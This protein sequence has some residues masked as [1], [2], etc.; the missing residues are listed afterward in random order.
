M[1]I[2][3]LDIT[4]AKA[5]DV[6]KPQPPRADIV[7]KIVKRQL[8][9]QKEDVKRWRDATTIAERQEIAPD[10]KELIKIYKDV[11]LDAH[12]SSLMQTVV[13]KCLAANYWLIDENG[14]V[15][16]KETKKLHASWFREFITYTIESK[17]WGHS[18]VQLGTIK[19]DAFSEIKLVPRENVIPELHVVKKHVNVTPNR[20]QKAQEQTEFIDYTRPEFRPWVIE[21]GNRDNLGLLHKATPLVL[22]KKNVF[23]AWSQYAELFGMPIRVGKTDIRDPEKLGNMDKMLSE[24]GSAA[25]GIF[26]PDDELEFVEGKVGDSYHV[27]LELINA[28]NGELSKLILGQ[29][30]TTEDG[31]SRSQA[32]VH[33]N[34]M[35]DYISAIKWFIR[36]TIQGKLL[37]VME[38]HGIIKPGLVFKW[39]NEEKV[40]MQGKLEMVVKLSQFYKISPEFIESTFG[41]PVEDLPPSVPFDQATNKSKATTIMREVYNLYKGHVPGAHVHKYGE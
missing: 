17:F 1:R 7:T 21:V 40:S 32:E 18:L 31:S 15:D 20:S 14:E 3:G 2:L 36:D 38:G 6:D 4:T 28:T 29:T 25:Y 33:E 27:F 11:V 10:R 19:D 39:D 30:M 12:L 5:V 24:M 23:S 16:E 37:P 35:N 22:W 9:R 13:L 41:I 34:V 26:D 8:I